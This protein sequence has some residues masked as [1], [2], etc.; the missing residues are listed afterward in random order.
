MSTH[1]EQ[2]AAYAMA[3]EKTFADDDWSRLAPHLAPHPLPL[4]GLPLGAL[5]GFALRTGCGPRTMAPPD[6]R[7]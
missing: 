2:L 4:V 6:G 1:T 3:F 7:V 5:A